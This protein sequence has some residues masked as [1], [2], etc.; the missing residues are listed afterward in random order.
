M[1]PTKT[2]DV[3]ILGTGLSGTTL[4]SILARNGLRVIMLDKATH[5]RF[6]IGESTITSTTLML[7]LLALRYDV[8]ELGH[9]ANISEVSEKVQA[10]SGVKLNFGF[11]YHTEGEEQ[12]SE[13]VNQALVVNELHLFRQDIDAYLLQVA[14]RYG[15]DIYQRTQLEEVEFDDDGVTVRTDR[16]FD[17]RCQYIVDGSGMRS[18]LAEKLGLRETP[19]RAKT[20]SRGLYTHML[21]VTPLDDCLQREEGEE[22]TPVPFHKG[23]LHHLFDGGWMWVIPFNNTPQSRNQLVSVGLMLDPRKHP[24]TDM[25]PEEE[26]A[27][28]IAQYPTMARQFEKARPVRDW[29]SS[30]R[31]QYSSRECTGDRYCLLSHSTGFIDPLFSR[32]LFNSVQ[33]INVLANL[34]LEAKQADDYSKA[35]FEPLE[36]M[37]QGLIDFNDELVHCSYI[38]FGKY[39]LWNAWFR[40]WLLTGAYGRLRVQRAILKAR[41]MDDMAALADLDGGLP[42]AVTDQSSIMEMWWEGV[43][44]MRA[45]EEGTSTPEDAESKIYALL[46]ANEELLPKIFDFLSPQERMTRPSPP[47]KVRSIV[48]DWVESMPKA[49]RDEYFDYPLELLFQRPV[50]KESDKA[51]R[52]AN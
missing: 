8:P 22:R 49:L 3:V 45:V 40:L 34:L 13:E 28:V 42:G 43:R 9:L 48:T 32:G 52:A 21:D 17:I 37:Q 11:A 41:R 46:A 23:T 10:S 25:P 1:K 6:A 33:T 12:R 16:D 51:A 18:V 24:R 14:I 44:I 15:C 26:F 39:S 50:V 19:T 27:K 47:D 35:K 20:H 30:G 4:G 2:C 38:S 36:R 7:E 5:P 29:I 31:I